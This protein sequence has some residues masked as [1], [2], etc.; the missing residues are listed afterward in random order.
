MDN[1]KFEGYYIM[2]TKT[3]EEAEKGKGLI[4]WVQDKPS[5]IKRFYNRFFLGIRWVDKEVYEEYINTR[6]T[7]EKIKDDA[8]AEFK[9]V[10][11]P[12]RKIYKKPP[13]NGT[14]KERANTGGSSTTDEV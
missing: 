11:M 12:K 1:S 5:A 3:Q 14:S 13:P 10:I 2:G 9:R 4:I 6:T 8:D 7:V